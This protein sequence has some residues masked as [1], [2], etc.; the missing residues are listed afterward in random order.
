MHYHLTQTERIE[1]S[2]LLQL[3][4]S[5]RNAALVLGVSPSTVCRELAR[6]K[7]PSGKYHA[8][9]ARRQT[10]SRR[11]RAN[12]RQRKLVGDTPLAQLIITKLA[13]I[14]LGACRWLVSA[15]LSAMLS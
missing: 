7:Q 14:P 13:L 6:N 11:L 4:H 1:L 9:Y 12:Q 10:K 8:I 2:L 3:G 5:Q 15:A